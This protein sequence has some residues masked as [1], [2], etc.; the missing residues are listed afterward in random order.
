[1]KRTIALLP[2]SAHIASVL[3]TLCLF[4]VAGCSEGTGA[5]PTVST[6]GGLEESDL[7]EIMKTAKTRKPSWMVSG[8]RRWKR[9][10][11]STDQDI[12]QSDQEI[13][14]SRTPRPGRSCPI[15]P[16]CKRSGLV[17]SPS[18]VRVFFPTFHSDLSIDSPTRR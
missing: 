16:R 13:A 8:G 5:G 15:R 7:A 6:P 1:M 2:A 11:L 3:L 18:T 14:L 17:L 12:W 4:F 10:V 9:Q